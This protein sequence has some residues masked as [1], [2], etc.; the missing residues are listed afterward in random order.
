MTITK[1]NRRLLRTSCSALLIA[2]V[3]G[4][5]AAAREGRRT[6]PPPTARDVPYGPHPRQKLDFWMAESSKHD[7]PA[8]LLVFIH[9]GGFVTGGKHEIDGRMVNWALKS[10][11][12]VAA[13]NYRFVTRHPFP[14]PMHDSAR[15]LQFL[16]SKATAWNIDPD[17]VAAYGGSAGA[18]IALWLAFHPDLAD[19]ENPDDP[20]ARQ[21]TRLKAVGAWAGQT[22]YNPREIRDWLGGRAWEHPSLLKL[23]GLESTDRN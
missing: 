23:F 4:L 7:Q 10:G 1:R 5:V 21:S 6:P 11:I 14:A 18:G 17:R 2:A 3:A 19:P 22:T 9:G 15:A 16:R 20:I 13:I 8:P 12:S